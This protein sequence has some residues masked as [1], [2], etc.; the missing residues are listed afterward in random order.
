MNCSQYL[1]NNTKTMNS[2]NE[3]YYNNT[4]INNLTLLLKIDNKNFELNK[5]FLESMMKLIKRCKKITFHINYDNDN[6]ILL[7][8]ILI[9]F[10]N[11]IENKIKKETIIFE[12]D[13]KY[14]IVK[15]FYQYFEEKCNLFDFYI[16][17]INIIYDI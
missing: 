7:N 15:L 5:D 6:E 14:V 3:N 8:N 1:N 13:Y 2:F 16:F 17:D 10:N 9:Y 4:L 12:V 11:F